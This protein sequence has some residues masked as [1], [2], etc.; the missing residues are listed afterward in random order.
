MNVTDIQ[1]AI[2]NSAN[3]ILSTNKK[4]GSSVTIKIDVANEPPQDVTD[5]VDQIQNNI[6]SY[7]VTLKGIRCDAFAINKLQSLKHLITGTNTTIITGGY[8]KQTPVALDSNLGVEEIEF[9]FI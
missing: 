5:L 7:N 6:S 8:I 2:L 9:I 3:D 1:I 4:N